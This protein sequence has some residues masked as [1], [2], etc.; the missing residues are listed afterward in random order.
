MTETDDLMTDCTQ[1]FPAQLSAI[2][3]AYEGPRL[4]V[5][6]DASQAL[7]KAVLESLG[8][9]GLWDSV[10]ALETVRAIFLFDKNVVFMIYHTP[11]RKLH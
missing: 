5:D 2:S 9:R 4:F 6:Q 11:S 8:R 7:D 3:R 1:T 10:A